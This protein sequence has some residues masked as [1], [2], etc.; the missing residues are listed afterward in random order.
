M[1]KK[2]LVQ[3]LQELAKKD[4]LTYSPDCLFRK[5]ANNGKSCAQYVTCAE[6]MSESII[7][8]A[9]RIE[10]EYDPKPEPDTLEKVALDMVA[11]MDD[12]VE[13]SRD[14]YVW[15]TDEAVD[16]FRK[17]LKVLGV[18]FDDKCE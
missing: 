15:V 3:E 18:M 14:N 11:W 16:P 5:I 1:S 4:N 2:N 7:S 8:F 13:A 6:C 10:A 9:D 12:I 17:R